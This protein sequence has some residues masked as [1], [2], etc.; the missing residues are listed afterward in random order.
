MGGEGGGA[1]GKGGVVG[2]GD[3]G[4]GEDGGGGLGCGGGGG[5]HDVGRRRWSEGSWAE[6]V[7]E[8]RNSVTRES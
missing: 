6:V 4:G 5:G 1:D 3:G 8:S 2:E 7:L